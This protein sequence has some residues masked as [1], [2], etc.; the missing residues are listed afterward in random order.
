MAHITQEELIKLARISQLQ[1]REDEIA[2]LLKH[3]ESILH[4]AQCVKDVAAD[5]VF[6]EHQQVNVMREDVVIKTDPEP[7]LAL[8][9]EREANFF[10]VPKIIESK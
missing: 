4:Y 1:L 2:P 5:G 3:I 9:P 8:A 6:D 10:V 7:L